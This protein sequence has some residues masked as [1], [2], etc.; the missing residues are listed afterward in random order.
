MTSPAQPDGPP[1]AEPGEAPHT[2]A[3][4]VGSE[5]ARERVEAARARFERSWIEDLIRHVKAVGLYTWTLVFGAELLWSVLPLLILLSSFAN[6]RIDDDL[7]EHI[8]LDRKAALI[9]K[10]VFRNTPEHAVIPILTGLL[11]SLAGAIAVVQ[12]LQVLYERIFEQQPRGWRDLPRVFVWL[13]V[14]LG[15]LVLEA[16][17]GHAVRT[18]VG[19]VVGRA[20]SF[21]LVTLFFGWTIHFLLAGRVRW[22]LV[23]EP[24]LVTGLGWL[25]LALF[26]GLFLSGDVVSD[27]RDYGTIGVVFTLLT[28]FV[29]IGTAIVLGAVGGVFWQTRVAARRARQ[30]S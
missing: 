10:E 21:V 7:S 4:H 11:F 29:L 13:V 16:I 9:M 2:H 17:I 1:H 18:A 19:P 15:F 22:R 12:S 20:V 3:H 6:H 24:A 28:W 25:C 8:G 26:A 14:L 23:V 30:A 5:R 27:R